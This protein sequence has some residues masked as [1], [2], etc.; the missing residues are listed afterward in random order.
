M[1]CSVRVEMLPNGFLLKTMM[2]K[3]KECCNNLTAPKGLASLRS[4][5]CKRLSVISV[6]YLLFVSVT[7]E[8]Q[9]GSGLGISRVCLMP[10]SE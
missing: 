7:L 1:I 2:L 6:F 5:L 3:K 10:A 9:H 4:N 8:A